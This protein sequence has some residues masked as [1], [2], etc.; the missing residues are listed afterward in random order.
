M[1]EKA[2]PKSALAISC[3]SHIVQDGLTTAV[4]VI[5]PVLAQVFGL[6]YAQVG[7]LK[8]LSSASQAI[9]EFAS[10]WISERIGEARLIIVGLVMSALG[11]GLLSFAI[12]RPIDAP[13]PAR[14]NLRLQLVAAR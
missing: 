11:Y 14:G 8:G 1:S 7:L 9:L 5:L 13:L 10:G 4:Y 12:E 2:A 3:T 6:S